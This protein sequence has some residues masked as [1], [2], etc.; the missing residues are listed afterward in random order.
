MSKVIYFCRVT[1]KCYRFF[2][3][4]FRKSVFFLG[5]ISNQAFFSNI[6]EDTT[7]SGI[8][9]QMRTLEVVMALPSEETGW[10]P[11]SAKTL[12]SSASLEFWFPRYSAPLNWLLSPALSMFQSPQPPLPIICYIHYVKFVL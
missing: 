4:V 6:R 5:K 3:K 12:T 8:S 9:K 11:P 1:C 2:F 10:C 7:K